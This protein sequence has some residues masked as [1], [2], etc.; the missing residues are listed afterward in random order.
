LVLRWL[1][2]DVPQ[3]EVRTMTSENAAKVYG[4]DLD[5]LQ[6]VADKIG[7]TPEEVAKPVSP[8][9][10]PTVSM[11]PPIAEAIYGTHGT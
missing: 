9:E 2:S 4:L 10:L 11:C 6:E 8:F 5:F 7:P 3:A 1:F